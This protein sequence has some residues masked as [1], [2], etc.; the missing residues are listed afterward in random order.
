MMIKEDYTHTISFFD[1]RA[2][3][4]DDTHRSISPSRSQAVRL[5]VR[6]RG[7]AILDIGCGTGVLFPELLAR[8]PST[9][10]GVDI[11]SGMAAR[12][13]EKFDHVSELRV[14][15]MDILA[16]EETGFDCAIIYNA[17]PHFPDKERLIGH[18]ASL[19]RPGGRLTVA[20]SRG[21]EQ[22]NRCHAN[23]PAGVAVELRP[24]C[25][26]SIQW[27]PWFH[28]DVQIDTA[29]LYIISGTTYN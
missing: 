18:V 28:V 8:E 27:Q 3:H 17:Y 2:L 1:A 25:E 13:R 21:R 20:H 22:I 12:A 5:A 10:V 23:I 6:E 26:E 4:W 15:C 7:A 14:L 29:D 11:S 24:A 19:L 9:L 16:F